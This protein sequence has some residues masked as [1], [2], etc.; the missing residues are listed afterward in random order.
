[1]IYGYLM[2][3][4]I[5]EDVADNGEQIYFSRS[6][7]G[8][9]W[10]DLNGGRPVLCSDVGEMGVRDP[11]GMRLEDGSFVILAT[12][13]RIAAGKGW[14]TAQY[15][16]SRDIILW[17]S[18]DLIHWDR[19]YAV[20]VAPE[21]AGCAWAPEAIYDREAD[22]YMVFWASMVQEREDPEPKQRIYRS[23][24]R[25]FVHFTPAEKYLEKP[26]HVIDSTMIYD[27]GSYY[28]YSKDC[29]TENIIIDSCR[30]LRE[31]PREIFSETLSAYRDLEG[32]LIF[33]LPD[34]K[35]W[36][37]MADQFIKG[38]GYLPMVT[39]DLASGQFRVLSP[40]EYD[41]GVTKK[42]HGSV[43]SLTESDYNNLGELL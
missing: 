32:P 10:E 5:G 2:I 41:M 27:R 14:D 25:D 13:L 36:C 16:G 12:D 30:T 3:H 37:L 43:M 17:R 19:P 34:G 42:R 15:R 28:R 20:T 6:R 24:T 29:T 18:R 31:K 7:D 23:W 38:K 21:K 8:L 1:M 4:F 22:M 35:S 39:E 40:E 11:Y 9:H 33:T 26:K